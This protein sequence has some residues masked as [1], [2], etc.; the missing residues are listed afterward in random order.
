MIT[1]PISLQVARTRF[2]TPTLPIT[3]RAQQL[4]TRPFDGRITIPLYLSDLEHMLSRFRWR[5]DPWNGRLDY[6]NHAYVT[7]RMLDRDAPAGDCDDAATYAAAVILKG[8]L[9]TRVW[10]ASYLWEGAAGQIEGHA[11]CEFDH[12]GKHKW[13]GNWNR[14]HALVG[15]P[16]EYIG[17]RHHVLIAN[18][19]IAN[20]DALDCVRLGGREN[21]A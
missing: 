10:F 2:L 14:G 9:A 4:A 3:Y 11:V 7:Q 20:L 18:R 19:W 12:D 8:R 6:V 1:M 5:A 17:A 15:E 13:I 21:L 16:L